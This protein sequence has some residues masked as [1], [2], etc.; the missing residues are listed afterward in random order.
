MNVLAVSDLHAQFGHVPTI[1]EKAAQAEII[2]DVGDHTLFGNGRKEYFDFLESLNKPCFVIH[3]NHE[4]RKETKEE[5][6][7]RKNIFF[8][9][10][11]YFQYKDI[12]LMGHG[13][14]GFSERNMHFENKGK[15]FEEAMKLTQKSIFITHAPPYKVLDKVPGIGH[16]G[17]K[18]YREFIERAQPTIALCGHIHEH[19]HEHDKIGKTKVIN[20]GPDGEIIEI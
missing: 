2:I 8:I 11:K 16:V 14:G 15:A 10:N 6:K 5:C 17:N 4:T 3:G 19:F 13:G 18:S 20:P 12:L 7:K 1:Q 9:N